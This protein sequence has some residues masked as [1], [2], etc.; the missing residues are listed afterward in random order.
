MKL[1]IVLGIKEIQGELN[2]VFKE[3]KIPIFSKVDIEG[4]KTEENVA[5][6]SNWFGNHKES[7][8]SVMFFTFVH[9]KDAD[10]ILKDINKLNLSKNRIRPFHAFQM[11]VEKFV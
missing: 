1:I 2:K 5:D 3:M 6:M 10:A 11:P 4:F 7:D 9:T 8:F